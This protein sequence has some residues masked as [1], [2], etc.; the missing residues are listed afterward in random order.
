MTKITDNIQSI[1]QQA[2]ALHRSGKLL[3]AG[4]CCLQILN[5]DPDNVDA[6]VLSGILDVQLGDK[7]R[8]AAC[9]LKAVTVSPLDSVLHFNYAKILKMLGKT[10][11]AIASYRKALKLNSHFIEAYI[12]LG[13]T[14]QEQGLG[15]KSVECFRKVLE[16]DPGH[17]ASHNNLGNLLRESGNLDAALKSHQQAI[18]L[19][20]E[21]AEA[22]NSLGI[23][24]Q[25]QGHLTDALDSF[26]RALKINPK[27]VDAYTNLGVTLKQLNMFDEAMTNFRKVIELRP[28]DDAAFS[29]LG[30]ALHERGQWD[31]AIACFQQAIDISP[32]NAMHY[33]NLGITQRLFGKF[34]EAIHNY[35][36]ALEINP[37]LPETY[38]HISTIKK[39]TDDDA[40]IKAMEKLLDKNNITDEHRM[41]LCFG[42]GK[43]FE[44]IRQYD[45]AFDYF[46]Q[47][48]KIKRS[49]IDYQVSEDEALCQQWIETFNRD[50]IEKY[51]AVGL[52]D[53]TPIFIVGMPRSGS[54]LIEQI[55]ACHP[56]VYG[57]GELYHLNKIILNGL[58]KSSN[59]N[60]Q[61]YIR[62]IS[63]ADIKH[64]GTEYI[65][66]LRQHAVGAPY[67]TD[68]MPQNFV[69]IGMIRLILP[70]AKV[71]H[72]QRNPIDTC[73][74][75]FK[76]NFD[77][78]H[79]YAYDLTEL[80]RYHCIYQRLMEHWDNILPGFVYNLQY[81]EMVV[82][83][84]AQTRSLLEY[85]GLPWDDACLNFH[86]STRAVGTASAFQVRHPIYKGSV[87]SWK[88]Y[89][90]QLEP[91]RKALGLA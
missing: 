28:E 67:I 87:N 13:N 35:R 10:D 5:T 2:N 25:A 6:L 78:L 49:N 19:N 21:L 61:E 48:N 9:F 36:L 86:T 88:R 34:D 32:G 38:F 85:C 14:L 82:E 60:Y 57:A 52:R 15:E 22:H 43:A 72:C 89:D 64:L 33:C 11:D 50:L 66:L 18:K 4:K 44:D 74:S 16:L 76:N 84:E 8:A 83:Q 77:A 51:D 79:E 41:H 31:E 45:Q 81:E 71:I 24:F 47:A 46:T 68:K 7:E 27:L 63:P 69:Y 23:V 29:Q 39:F 80:G 55:L 56:D 75:C 17:A 90:K 54:S 30:L 65:S 26:N 40:D 20:P 37:E 3:E 12:A 42:L 1:L 53:K 73:L 70:D 58:S 62:H 59:K 91:L